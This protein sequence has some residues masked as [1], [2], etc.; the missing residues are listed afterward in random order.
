MFWID[1]KARTKTGTTEGGRDKRSLESPTIVRARGHAPANAIIEE[2]NE[3]ECRIR[4]VVLYEVNAILEFDATIAECTPIS[5]RGHVTSRESVPPRY[6]YS[7]AVDRAKPIDTENQPPP[8]VG[9][10]EELPSGLARRSPRFPVRFALQYRTVSEGFKAAKCANISTGGMLIVCREPLERGRLLEVQFALPDD[11]L[12]RMAPSAR[13][14][15]FRDML[16]TARVAFH[17]PIQ[18][19]LY[20]CGLKFTGLKKEQREDIARYVQ[21]LAG[22]KVPKSP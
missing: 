17:E 6:R 5:V 7:L 3:K 12:V 8:G 11:V 15:P 10:I 13:R 21:A 1:F 18:D 19:G 16:V 20:K 2:L 14:R 9:S 22:V 4:T